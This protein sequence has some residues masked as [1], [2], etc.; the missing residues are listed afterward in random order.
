MKTLYLLGG[1]MGVGKTTVGKLLLK[2]LAAGVFLD[3]DWCWNASPFVV[4]E[5]TKAMVL[6]NITHL[7]KNFLSC[8]VYENVIFCWVMHEQEILDRILYGL[9]LLG[10]QGTAQKTAVLSVSLLASP[11]ALTERILADAA[12]GLRDDRAVERSLE[13]LKHYDSLN[14]IKIDVSRLSA[15]EAAGKIAALGAEAA[16][17][18]R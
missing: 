6:D 13:R 12:A 15:E 5:E 16:A 17:L 4:N 1:P 9:G 3:G 10:E 14:T 18:F 2:K 7:L 11:E 8:S